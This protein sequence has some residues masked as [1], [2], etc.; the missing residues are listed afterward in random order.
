[1]A[2]LSRK[3]LTAIEKSMLPIVDGDAEQTAAVKDAFAKFHDALGDGERVTTDD[4]D[5]ILSEVMMVGKSADVPGEIIEDEPADPVAPIMKALYAEVAPIAKRA[6]ASDQALQAAFEKAYGAVLAQ[7]DGAIEQAVEVTAIELAKAGG[8][9][10]KKSPPMDPEDMADGG[11]DENSEED[12]AKL[13]NKFG[14]GEES[15]IM[16]RLANVERENAALRHDRDMVLFG[17][18]AADV[19]APDMAEDLLNLHKFD[20]DLAKR[21]EKRMQGQHTLL[22]KSGAWA[23][24][25]GTGQTEGD[26]YGQ[27]SGFAKALQSDAQKAGQKLSFAKAF[28]MACDQHQDVYAEYRRAQAG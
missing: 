25:I 15:P 8:G 27:L 11:A 2:S 28:S 14:A 1:M 7:L 9:K 26:A 4:V 20:P 3:Q 13:L 5:E 19:G 17:K 18:R 10:K 6:G 23:E 16:K 12:M 22:Q 24:E 21:I